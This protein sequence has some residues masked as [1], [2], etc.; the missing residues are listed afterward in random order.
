MTPWDVSP[1]FK[2]DRLESIAHLLSEVRSNV[3]DLHNDE[4]GDTN[5]S[6]GYR[7]YECSCT[8]IVRKINEPGYEWLGIVSPTGRFTFSISGI[9]VRFWKGEPERLPT[10]K[11]IRSPEATQQLDLFP[12]SGDVKDLI[13][14]V[15]LRTDQTK[16]VER[17]YFIG[18]TETN[19]I[20]V[21]WEIPLSGSIT[22]I[23][24]EADSLPESVELES[25]VSR[26]RLKTK[27]T[28]KEQN[29]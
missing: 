9:P 18:Y 17:A 1:E 10:G 6:L 5:R 8:N 7:A 28:V 2:P 26:V 24:S 20:A 21:N 29:G 13:W 27:K 4:L 16:Q 25:A 22:H 15:V 19:E 23:T 14:Y 3:L 12:C 11:L